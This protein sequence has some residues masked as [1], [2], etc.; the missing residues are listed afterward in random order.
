MKIGYARVSTV[1]QEAGEAAQ[2]RDL[3]AW[4]AEKIFV[5]RVSS[6][7]ERRDELEALIGFVRQGDVVAVTRLDRLARSIVDAIELRDRITAKG[8]ALQVVNLGAD[9]S[10]ATGA[11][12]FNIIGSV[13]EFERALMLERQKEGIAAAKVAGKYKGRAPTARR[14]AAEVRARAAEGVPLA[15]I[16]RD[17]GIGRSS[18]YRCLAAGRGR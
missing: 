5:E 13:A 8:A 4:G 1:D 10:T 12:I 2:R 18:I 11:L 7:A 6:V 9:S 16:A 17:L 14:Q 15:R 3:D